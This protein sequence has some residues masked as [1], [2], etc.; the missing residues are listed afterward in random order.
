MRIQHIQNL[1]RAGETVYPHKFDVSIALRDFIDK[2]SP[3]KSEETSN[4]S[5]SIAG[6]I[7]IEF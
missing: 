2:Y 3:L 7:R 5:V 4:D 1:K 6:K